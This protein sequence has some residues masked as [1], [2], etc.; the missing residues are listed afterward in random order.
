[1]THI[2]PALV[3]SLTTACTGGEPSADEAPTATAAKRKKQAKRARKAKRKKGRKG[4]RRGKSDRKPA[5]KADK[6]AKAQKRREKGRAGGDRYPVCTVARAAGTDGE[7]KVTQGGV[8]Q[9]SLL[10]EGDR[11]AI[12]ANQTAITAELLRLGYAED[13]EK[14][15]VTEAGSHQ[16]FKKE[17]HSCVL[18][19][20]MSEEPGVSLTAMELICPNV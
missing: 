4:K 1:M 8:G 13:T 16:L 15:A 20:R 9:C 12:L 19:I 14:A 18:D 2:L 10:Y 11:E 7:L 17:R 6:Q 5:T 3:L